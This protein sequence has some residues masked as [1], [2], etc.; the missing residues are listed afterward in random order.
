MGKALMN[1]CDSV[2]FHPENCCQNSEYSYEKLDVAKT[3]IV[4]FKG[5]TKEQLLLAPFIDYN[6]RANPL[7]HSF[8]NERVLGKLKGTIIGKAKIIAY[9]SVLSDTK[10][11]SLESLQDGI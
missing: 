9:C 2:K 7:N 3:L 11:F 10:S 1:F 5:H 6:T 4:F 8:V